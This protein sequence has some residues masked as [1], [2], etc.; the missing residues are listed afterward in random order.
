VSPRES[1]SDSLSLHLRGDQ[2]IRQAADAARQYGKMQRLAHEEFARLA[3]VVEEL[4]ANLYDHGGVAEQDEVE[5]AMSR[6]PRGIHIK[7][8]CPGIPFDPFSAPRS[9]ESMK[10]G[11]GAGLNLIRAWAELISYHSTDEGNR[12]ELLLPVSW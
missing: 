5:L 4:V 2:A 6:D 12:L 9:D 11:G 8:A 10:H 3:I 1:N 7:I